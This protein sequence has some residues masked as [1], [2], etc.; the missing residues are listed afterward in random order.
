MTFLSD[1][2]WNIHASIKEPGAMNSET[3]LHLE[4]NNLF[5]AAVNEKNVFKG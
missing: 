3:E 2:P 5:I 4:W 1:I